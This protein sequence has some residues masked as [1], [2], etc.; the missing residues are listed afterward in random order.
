MIESNQVC[1]EENGEG[2]G[3]EPDPNMQ[4][5]G[6][7]YVNPYVTLCCTNDAGSAKVGY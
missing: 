3:Y 6:S 4:C 1:C 5:C 2:I 7:E